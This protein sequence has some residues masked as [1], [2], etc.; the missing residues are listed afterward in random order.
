[1]EVTQN[2]IRE[3]RKVKRNDWS[4]SGKHIVADLDV[5]Y[6]D[7]VGEKKGKGRSARP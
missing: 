6:L 2:G 3:Q 1:M 7:V 5:A 4:K